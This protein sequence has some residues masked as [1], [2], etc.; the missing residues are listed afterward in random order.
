MKITTLVPAYKPKYL[1]ELLV[2]MRNQTVKPEKIIFSDDSPDQSFIY[3]L[4]GDQIK[5]V[6]ADLNIEVI[7][8]PR[9]G[10][11]N[12]FRHLMR[13]YAGKT[14]IF[15]IQLDDD[16]CYPNF[17]EQHLKAHAIGYVPC[18]ISRRW[19]AMESGQPLRDLGVPSAI[20]DHPQRMLSLD[21]NLLFTH[22]VGMSANWLGE[23]SNATFRSDMVPELDDASMGG[24]SFS[25]LEDLGGFLKASLKA[26]VGYINEHL[27]YFRTSAEH[28][29][30]NPMGR[31]MKL[32][33]LAYV[34]LAIG[35]R[36]LGY[37]SSEQERAIVSALCP[38]IKQRYFLEE[39]MK[40]F[41]DLMP[42][43][44]INSR[45]SEDLFIEMWGKFA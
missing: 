12:N 36:R 29:S 43:L 8:G 21:A 38:I 3:I 14:D 16:I 20:S 26:P 33:H 5:E 44:E 28:N 40:E 37:I 22:T 15:H 27:G 39:D 35:C 18:V 10:G 32:A 9:S 19:T 45:N 23:F 17:Y 7:P 34:A 6:T 2:S 31:P 30:A 4:N 11:W 24:I 25:G 1:F 41:C 42:F 13:I